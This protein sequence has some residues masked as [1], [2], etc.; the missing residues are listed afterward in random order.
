MARTEK[1]PP[2]PSYEPVS[3]WREIALWLVAIVVIVVAAT[4]VLV[5]L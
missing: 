5:A 4:L 1:L 3:S 2:G